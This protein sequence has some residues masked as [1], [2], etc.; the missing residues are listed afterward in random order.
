MVASKVVYELDQYLSETCTSS[1]FK[2]KIPSLEGEAIFN[3][4]NHQSNRNVSRFDDHQAPVRQDGYL[5]FKETAV[6]TS[7]PN[8]QKRID[9]LQVS[10]DRQSL[11]YSPTKNTVDDDVMLM[12]SK[13]LN[14]S[15]AAP[16]LGGK[17]KRIAGLSN[18][19]DSSFP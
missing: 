5:Q 7:I 18:K 13:E 1:P 3:Q 6:K 16:N 2:S 12:A 14:S 8:L 9:D 4:P 15:F 19:K 17:T 10:H 11:N